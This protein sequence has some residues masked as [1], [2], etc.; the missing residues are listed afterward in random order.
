MSDRFQ[1]PPSLHEIFH[2]DWTDHRENFPQEGRLDYPSQLSRIENLLNKE[3]HRNVER[4]AVLHN[5]GFLTN[6]GRE[7]IQDVIQQAGDLAFAIR[8]ELKGYEAYLLILAAHFHDVGNML[9]REQHEKKI[10]EIM[11]ALGDKV[12]E[13]RPERMLIETIARA[14]GG[15]ADAAHTDR[16][17]LKH[18]P[19]SEWMLRTQVR[20]QLLAALLRFGDELAENKNRT[21]TAIYDILDFINNSNNNPVSSIPDKSKVY[22]AYA[23]CLRSSLV[24]PYEHEVQLHFEIMYDD[25]QKKFSKGSEQV[26]LFDEIQQRIHKVRTEMVYFARH[27]RT[28]VPLER[29]VVKIEILGRRFQ[30]DALL[31]L[32]YIFQDKGYPETVANA[33]IPELLSKAESNLRSFNGKS[34]AK[35]IKQE[36]ST[37]A[38]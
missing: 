38:A 19:L 30:R 34:L 22:H 36:A 12:G 35:K 37:S 20:P 6:H 14:H 33:K 3:V 29:L 25:T 18:V 1:T 32:R 28:I 9:G 16:D 27:A 31:S 17:T 10:A 2:R 21:D 7:H 11:E 4:M 26:Y 13:D 23:A 5:A 15:Y 24:N 8:C